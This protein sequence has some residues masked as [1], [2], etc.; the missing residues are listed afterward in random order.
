MDLFIAP[1]AGIWCRS[2]SG[3]DQFCA[4]LVAQAEPQTS[5]AEPVPDLLPAREARR[6][7]LHVRLAIEAGT[8]A[9][10]GNDV[11]TSE[12]MTVFASAM[13]DHQITDYMCRTLADSSPMLSPTRF[14]NS[15]HNAASGY[16]SIGAGNRLVSVA[17]AAPPCTFT[18]GILEAASLAVSEPGTVLL[19]AHDIPAPS[20]LD[21]VCSTRQPFALAFLVSS[22]RIA[23]QWR[24]MRLEYRGTASPWPTPEPGWL[25]KLAMD[26][27]CARGI[28]LLEALAGHRPATLAWPLNEAAHL[29]LQLGPGAGALPDPT[30]SV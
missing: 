22:Q 5:P 23:P 28:P 1:R 25:Q 7:P 14:H 11:A 3:W 29:R 30:S 6:A 16:W 24:G 20:P 17:I 2:V 19:I 13:G 26:N 12:V 10:R 8:Q 9:C 21:A 15:V 18:A 4:A 27:E